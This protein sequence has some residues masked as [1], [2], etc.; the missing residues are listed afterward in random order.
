M[1]RSA[2]PKRRATGRCEPLIQHLMLDDI[3]YETPI[4][5]MPRAA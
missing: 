4:G 5:T 3:E 1:K 2:V